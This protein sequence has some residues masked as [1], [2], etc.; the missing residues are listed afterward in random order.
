M[1]WP[2]KS[3][4]AEAERSAEEA[5]VAAQRTAQ[6]KASTPAKAAA[7]ASTAAPKQQAPPTTAKPP[8]K[9]T[10]VAATPPSGDPSGDQWNRLRQCESGN[11][12]RAL[13]PGGRFRGA[14]QFSQTTWDWV[15]GQVAPRLVEVDPID[16]APGDQDNMAINLY[17]MRGAGQWPVCGK[18]LR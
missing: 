14:Y 12:Y 4:V 16:A 18:Y 11:N 3:R 6:P 2:S 10:V 15:A 7:P 9:T 8:V 17:R 1:A 13:S 5:R